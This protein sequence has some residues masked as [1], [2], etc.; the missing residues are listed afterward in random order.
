M[1]IILP[2]AKKLNGTLRFHCAF[3]IGKEIENLVEIGNFEYPV[4]LRINSADEDLAIVRGKRGACLKQQS[5]DPGGEKF[6]VFEIKN[7][8]LG[9]IGVD[10]TGNMLGS[11][12]DIF[13]VTYRTFPESNYGNIAFT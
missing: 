3:G 4:K 12:G 8:Q 6:D 13:N 2:P 11:D 5:Q 9:T 10:K 1:Y 7:D